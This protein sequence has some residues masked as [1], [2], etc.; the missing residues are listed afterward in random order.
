MS[1]KTAREQVYKLIYERCVN[2]E[3]EEFSLQLALDGC[4][5]DDGIF[6]RKLFEG[7]NENYEFLKSIVERYSKGFSFERIFKIDCAVIMVAAYEILYLDDIPVKV[8]VNEALEFV[9]AYSADKSFSFVNGVLASVVKEKEVLL[10]E[11][12]SELQQV[13]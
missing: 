11:R 4:N 5:E 13:D 3:P 12:E 8:S 9:K 2:E 1:R 6:I 10:S 7:V